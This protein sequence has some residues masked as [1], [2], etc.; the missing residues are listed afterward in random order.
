MLLTFPSG[1]NLNVPAGTLLIRVDVVM[2]TRPGAGG[3]CAIIEAS[4]LMENLLIRGGEPESST[5]R[6]IKIL[7]S[8]L[9]EEIGPNRA[10]ILTRNEPVYQALNGIFQSFKMIRIMGHSP[11][12]VCD[13]TRHAHVMAERSKYLKEPHEERF[14]TTIFKPN[15]EEFSEN[16]DVKTVHDAVQ[17]L[18]TNVGLDDLKNEQVKLAVQNIFKA[19]NDEAAAFQRE[20]IRRQTTNDIPKSTKMKEN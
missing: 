5:D 17:H 18:M 15:K 3:Y 16:Q 7:A 4:D 14:Y 19:A 20:S 6:I 8:R 1:W 2:D 11:L 13:A 12:A 9:A 10:M